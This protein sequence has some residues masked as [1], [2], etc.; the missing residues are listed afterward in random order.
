MQPTLWIFPHVDLSET[1]LTDAPYCCPRRAAMMS[2]SQVDHPEF[3]K[4]VVCPFPLRA[5]HLRRGPR[6][7][8]RESEKPQRG[9]LIET[10]TAC[11]S[12]VAGK[13]STGS[14]G[15]TVQ[16]NPGTSPPKPRGQ[17]R[18]P[19]TKVHT[20]EPKSCLSL[21][22]SLSLAAMSDMTRSVPRRGRLGSSSDR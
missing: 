7:G 11:D 22:P 16:V 8:S 20:L 1:T 13:S 17:H 15:G 21:S 19:T 4:I 12:S 9:H 14:P 5:G 18:P 10:A 3:L 2:K 6:S